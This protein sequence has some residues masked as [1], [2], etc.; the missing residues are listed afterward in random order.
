[1][2]TWSEGRATVA[3]NDV[4]NWKEL[5]AIR[6]ALET[7]SEELAGRTVLVRTDNTAALAA[8]NCGASRFL[9]ARR[10]MSLIAFLCMQHRI[11]LRA[12]HLVG[13]DNPADAPSRGVAKTSDK[14]FTF[15]WFAD[16]N[17]FP[18]TI[19][20][21]ASVNGYNAQLGCSVWFSSANPVQRHAHA[22]SGR[23]IW[24][25][26]PW[27]IIGEVLDCAGLELGSTQHH[28]HCGAASHT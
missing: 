6:L 12:L 2:G 7:Y 22:I 8:V 4:I 26:P 11:K 10:E 14:D 28:G 5:T 16:F 25:N 20:C 18:H 19:D 3:E 27:E 17:E 24:A 9:P 21:C 23:V 13:I 15:A 1:M